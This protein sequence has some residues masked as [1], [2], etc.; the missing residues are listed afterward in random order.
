[1][2]GGTTNKLGENR[3]EIKGREKEEEYQDEQHI[4]RRQE[5]ENVDGEESEN[6]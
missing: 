6:G 4:L 5:Y 2:G 1:M 3:R